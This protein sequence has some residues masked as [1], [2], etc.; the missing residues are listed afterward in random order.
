[1]PTRVIPNCIILGD[2]GYGVRHYFFTPLLNPLTQEEQLYNEAHI[3]TRNVIERTFGVC[4]RKF[5]VLAYGCR[6]KK[7]TVLSIIIACAV[8]HN[9]ARQMG[10]D[11]PP[12]P[13]DINQHELQQL[14]EDGQ[15]PEVNVIDNQ[16]RGS[17]IRR[18]FITNFFG[19]L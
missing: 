16:R 17:E 8:L 19:N 3:R 5:P 11:E 10:E 9:I 6:L 2:G 1:M 4:K 15:I 12:L 13:A 18:N 14:I 7:E